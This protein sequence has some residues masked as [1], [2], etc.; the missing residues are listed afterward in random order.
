MP[1]KFANAGMFEGHF[2]WEPAIQR[3][4]V[5]YQRTGDIRSEFFRDYSR[6]LHSDPFRR[7]KHKTQV[8][9]APQNDHIC[10]RIEHVNHVA[11]VSYT[12]AKELGLNTE[13]TSAIAYGHDIGHTPF[14]HEGETLLNSI[15]QRDI[16]E[17]FWHEKNGLFVC[18]S[19]ATLQDVFGNNRNLMLTYAVRDGIISHCG[20]VNQ[21]SIFP[22][23]D[24]IDLYKINRTNEY[25]PYTWEGCIVKISDKISYLGRDIED[26]IEQRLLTPTLLLELK[27]IVDK[28]LPGLGRLNNTVLMHHLITNLCK[29][30][31]PENG[32]M[33]S[34]NHLDL[35][36]EV[37]QFNYSYIYKHPKVESHKQYTRLIITTLYE[38]LQQTYDR[39]TITEN[40]DELS[41]K[42]P[43]LITDFHNW[44]IEYSD[45]DLPKRKK[46]RLKNRIIYTIS[47]PKD[48][49][50]SIIGFIAGMT[51]NYAIRKYHEVIS[52]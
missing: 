1:G 19:I 3:Y 9:F 4:G 47:N 5:L 14:G 11:S 21:E 36:N 27:R 44:L 25:Q 22:R 16:G 48:F 15:S 34:Q 33:L 7:L 26:A 45:I 6:I 35:M 38:F 12:I 2:N 41:K 49:A 13:L 32:I 18:D 51:D 28:Y 40:L 30:S 37:K 20:E 24:A 39:G 43:L 23:T 42:Y 46:R 50:R 17:N 29:N 10:T 52:F 31:N 8:F